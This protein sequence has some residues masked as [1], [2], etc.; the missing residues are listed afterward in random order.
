[1]FGV[2]FVKESIL[3]DRPTNKR[4]HERRRRE[5]PPEAK[6]ECRRRWDSAKQRPRNQLTISGAKLLQSP[7]KLDKL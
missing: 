2:V 6:D 7:H 3:R 1:M 5:N 4:D